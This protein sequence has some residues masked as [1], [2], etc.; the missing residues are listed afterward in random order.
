MTYSVWTVDPA[1]AGTPAGEA[2][3]SIDKAFSAEGEEIT[4]DGISH[5]VRVPVSGKQYYVKRYTS[6][7]NGPGK[8]FGPRKSRG[9]WKNLLLFRTLGLAVPPIVAYGKRGQRGVLVTEEV[10]DTVDLSEL[11]NDNAPELKN[12]EWVA[13]VSSQVAEGARRM[14]N[15]GFAHNDLKWRNLLVTRGADPKVYFIDCPSGRKWW[16]PFLEYRIIKDLA[17]LDKVAKYHLT[18]EQRLSFYL[19]YS[20]KQVLDRRDRK[21]I[22]KVLKFFKGRE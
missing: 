17:C 16:G 18:E 19:D 22:K 20:G 3:A 11:V 2:F 4:R 8:L 7:G 10:I 21:R 15:H 6:R 1:F 12:P 14:H 9:E 13:K 5:V